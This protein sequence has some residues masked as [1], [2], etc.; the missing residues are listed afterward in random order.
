M[1]AVIKRRHA[2]WCFTLNN[3]TDA[4]LSSIRGLANDDV[5]YLVVGT[6]SGE[7]GTP[8]LQGFIVFTRRRTMESA[9]ELLGSRCHLES[10]RGTHQQAAD[11]CKKDGDYF[12]HGTLPSPGKRND[13]EGAVKLLQDTK[14]ITKCA[15][16]YPELFVRYGR[17]LR[18]YFFSSTILSDRNFKTTVV[19]LVGPPGVGKSRLA[20]ESADPIGRIYYKPNGE[21]W[22]G[23]DGQD[24]VIFD[25]FYGNYPFHELLHICDRYPHKVPIKGGFVHFR[26]KE[27]YIT[28]N[29]FPSKWYNWD[30]VGEA[31]ALYRRIDK[32]L[33]I[34]FAGHEPVDAAPI[35]E[36][37][38][39]VLRSIAY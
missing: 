32:Y 20:F 37:E 7:N 4:E 27:I 18:D 2:S 6:E 29:R 26:S 10:M 15:D 11:Y 3:Y 9:K 23:Y 28:S 24:R 38:T 30:K 13:L 33:W 39:G 21:W 22:D 16:E 8:H 19:V 14:S 1:P 31:Q 36:A 25:D 17:G 5:T 34:G 35:E 12:E